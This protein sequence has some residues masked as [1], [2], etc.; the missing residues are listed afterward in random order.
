LDKVFSFQ[1][2]APAVTFTKLRLSW[3]NVGNDTG[4]YSLDQYYSSSSISGGFAL[5]STIPDPMIKPENVESWELGL[6]AKFFQ[7]RLG[8]DVALYNSSTTNQIVSVDIDPIVGA[9]SMNINAGEINNKGIE[10]SMFATPVR[11][12]DFTWNVNLNWTKNKNTLVSLQDGWDPETPLETDMGT[13]IGGRLHVYSYVGEEMHQIYGFGLQKAPAGSYYI[14]DNGDKVDCSGQVLLN[15][16]TGL[17]SRTDLPDV[18]LGK[19]NPDWRGGFN[20]SL[21]YKDFTLNMAFT[22]QYG[23]NRFSVTDAIL[24]YQGKLT[25]SL[26]GRYDG[27]VAEG[28]NVISTN[29]DG[30]MVCEPN[31]TITSNIYTYYQALTQDR[32]NGEAHTYSTSFLKLKEV[33]L[34]YNLPQNL[35]AKTKVLQG[36]SIAFF[37][38]NLFSIDKWPQF[39]PEGG[40][41][42]GTNVFNGIEAGAFP[43][44]RT[45]GINVRLSF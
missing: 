23:G 26:E 11:T 18:F 16:T 9:S 45:K 12:S 42:T 39:D 28:V 33:R 41:M 31:N 44:T 19:V 38:T 7:N 43:M 4:P 20:S 15:P 40:M 29:A 30:T 1:T 36:A 5:P 22:Y 37:A 14:D 34:E 13:T 17:P 32:Y 10:V 3:A 8:F 6:E 21:R 24:S 35:C 2:I 27:I 25:N